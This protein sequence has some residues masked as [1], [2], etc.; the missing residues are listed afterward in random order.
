[1]RLRVS[2]RSTGNEMHIAMQGRL[3]TAILFVKWPKGGTSLA[4][5]VFLM[6]TVMIFRQT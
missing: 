6:S 5:N 1:M 3:F 2:F 4:G